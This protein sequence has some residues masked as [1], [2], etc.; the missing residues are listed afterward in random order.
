MTSKTATLI[1]NIFT[2]SYSK[3]TAGLILTD[4]SNHLPI[5]ISTNLTVY[6]K[7]DIPLEM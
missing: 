4:I 2:N 7:D 3:Q 6:Q 1:D 5:F